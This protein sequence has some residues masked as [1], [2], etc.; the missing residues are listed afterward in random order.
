LKTNDKEGISL[1]ELIIATKN[2]GKAK[3]FA[4]LFHKYGITVK[5][6]LDLNTEIPDVEETGA[7]FHENARLK[8]ETIANKLETTVL[9]DDSGL[10]VDA[11]NGEPG[12]Y[13]ARYAGEPKNDSQN[14]KKL[15]QALTS[16]NNRA[17]RFVCVLAW[18]MPNK[19][20]IYAEGSC[21][22][23]IAKTMSGESGFGYDPLFIPK[24]YEVTMAELG[25]EEKNT[26]SHR[27]HA[28]QQLET[29]L[30][31]KGIIKS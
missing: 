19:P 31:E 5:S 9:A 10:S 24:G 20:V 30:V 13:S 2:P 16:H 21:N 3:E 29:T 8:A 25:S 26:I 1:K 22:G 14:N 6:L 7:T 15:L 11:L 12:V 27:F 18:A 23:K 17:A 28:M 4:A